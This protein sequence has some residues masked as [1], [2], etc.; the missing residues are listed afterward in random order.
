MKLHGVLAP[1]IST[2]EAKNENLDVA[3]FTSNVNAHLQAGL[4]GIVVCGSTGEAALLS[5]DERRVLLDAARGVTPRDRVLLMGCGAESTRQTLKRCQ[6]AKAGGA[7]AAL[8]VAPHYYSYAMNLEALR[9][10]YR[11]VADGSPI[12][13]VLYNIPKYMHF[14]LPAELV[15]ELAKHPNV[16]GIK[17]SSGDINML[18]GFLAAQSDSFTVL[19]GNGGTYVP[20]LEAGSRGGILAVSLFAPALSLQM[21]DAFMR[22][23]LAAANE[24]QVVMKPLA[25]EI[26]AGFGVAG[27]KTACDVA[28][29]KGGS[30]RRPLI[31]LDEK[32]EQRV[33]ELLS[34][35]VVAA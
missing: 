21:Y 29:L 17:D 14:A 22:G 13:V 27:V 34:G 1:V 15:A 19:T 30:V 35:I 11:A 4:H 18:K 6:D 23:D 9:T 20:A 2:F 31:D 24:A 12:P 10:H 8:V 26:V 16:V 33:R 7:D 3:S 28:G 5:E 25:V 32:A